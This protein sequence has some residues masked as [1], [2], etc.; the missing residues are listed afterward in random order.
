M[1]TLVAVRLRILDIILHH[2]HCHIR[3]T[4]DHLRDPVNIRAERADNT[5]ARNIAQMLNH[6]RD[7]HL[8]STTFKLLDNTLRRFQARFDVLDRIVII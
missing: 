5:D 3:L 1:V 8:I 2:Q 6:V 7:R 4:R